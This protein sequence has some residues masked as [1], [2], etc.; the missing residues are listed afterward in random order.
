MKIVRFILALGVSLNA[1]ASDVDPNTVHMREFIF[2]RHYCNRF[3]GFEKGA[4]LQPADLRAYKDSLS[5]AIKPAPGSDH[6]AAF[7]RQMLES[8]CKAAGHDKRA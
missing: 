2:E 5:K 8:L 7:N 1:L 6:S 3:L 4:K